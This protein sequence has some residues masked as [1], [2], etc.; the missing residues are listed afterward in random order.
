MMKDWK[1]GGPKSEQDKKNKTNKS[2]PDSIKHPTKEKD[3]VL[4]L[5]QVASLTVLPRQP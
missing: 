4:S 5:V 3:N 1:D 2:H